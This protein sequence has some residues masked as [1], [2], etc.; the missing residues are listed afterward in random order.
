MSSVNDRL[1]IF[2]ADTGEKLT[3][4]NL[5]IT[6]MGPPISFLLDGKQYIAVAGAPGGAAA[7]RGGPGGGGGR[8]AAGPREPAKLWVFSLDGKMPMPGTPAN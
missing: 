6:Q 7:G 8:G 3:E 1:M 5:H 2:K 4:L